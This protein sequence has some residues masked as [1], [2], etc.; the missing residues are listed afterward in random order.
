MS[1]SEKHPLVSVIM[2]AYNASAHI[3]QAIESVASQTYDSWELVIVDDASS[4]DTLGVAEKAAAGDERVTIVSAERNEGAARSRNRAIRRS[5]GSYIAF[6]DSDDYWEPGKLSMQMLPLE[7]RLTHICCCS[8]YLS[9]ERGGKQTARSVFHVPERVSYSDLLKRNLFSCSTLVASRELLGDE[10]FDPSLCHEDYGAWLKLL[11]REKVAYGIDVPLATYRV[12]SKT[13]SSNKAKAAMGRWRVLKQC[14][15]EP[16]GKR[17]LSFA[18][19]AI[20]G[21]RKYKRAYH[22]GAR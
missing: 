2:P 21:T 16:F 7:A 18:A 22:G 20:E 13:R 4:D 17:V 5:R 6:L 3:G 9:F 14:T 15:D 11:K 1:I 19:Y 8:Y 10:P 12:A